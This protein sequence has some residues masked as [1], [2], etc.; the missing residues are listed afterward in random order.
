MEAKLISYTIGGEVI[1]LDDD[2]NVIGKHLLTP[3]E[4]LPGD[5]IPEIAKINQFVIDR[6][7]ELEASKG[8]TS[9][10]E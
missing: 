5:I 2:G 10:E 7:A 6:T 8:S 4:V 3:K 1:D 9:E